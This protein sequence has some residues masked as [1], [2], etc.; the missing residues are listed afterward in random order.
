ML[1]LNNENINKEKFNKLPTVTLHPSGTIILTDENLSPQ[2]KK[3]RENLDILPKIVT[4]IKPI[5]FVKS[6]ALD[7]K[8]SGNI[9]GSIPDFVEAIFRATTVKKFIKDHATIKAIPT[10]KSN[11][12]TSIII[13]TDSEDLAYGLSE[14]KIYL[15]HNK[16]NFAVEFSP[17]YEGTTYVVEKGTFFN[18]SP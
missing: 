4:S 6:I 3:N 18:I 14:L 11:K 7:V 9:Y 13:V 5:N 16:V 2:N 1:N 10:K 15:T 17:H 12:V 8:I